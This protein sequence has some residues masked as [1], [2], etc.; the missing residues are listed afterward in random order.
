ML[1]GDLLRDV[2]DALAVGD[3]AIWPARS[4]LATERFIQLQRVVHG[5]RS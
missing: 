3:D 5:N 1:P 2:D 4:H